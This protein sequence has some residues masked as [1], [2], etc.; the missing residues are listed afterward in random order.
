[1]TDLELANELKLEENTKY[2]KFTDQQKE[3]NLKQEILI[4]N[5]EV[6]NQKL[7]TVI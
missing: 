6:E 7:Q 5:L 2:I 1:M 3:W 4:H